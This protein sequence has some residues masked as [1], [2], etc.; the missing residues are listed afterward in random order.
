MSRAV[1]TLGQQESAGVLDAL[2]FRGEVA[3]TLTALV[4]AVAALLLAVVE[5]RVGD[6]HLLVLARA[7][8]ARQ[9]A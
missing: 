1:P 3:G 9:G 7:S 4:D 2:P 8:A 5:G 6:D